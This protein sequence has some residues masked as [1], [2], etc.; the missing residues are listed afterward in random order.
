MTWPENSI[1]ESNAK[2]YTMKIK[3][4]ILGCICT[5]ISW[6]STAQYVDIS[7]GKM[8]Y[9]G[10][11]EQLKSHESP[12]W[13]NNAKLGIFIHWGL[14]SV[15]AYASTE[16]SVEELFAEMGK[17]NPDMAK[18]QA[19]ARKWFINNGYAEWYLN[20]LRIKGS[21][22][23]EYHKENYGLEY[24]YYK[25]SEDFSR[26]TLQWDSDAM[27]ELF[28]KAGARYVV[29]TTKHHD[30]YTLWPSRVQ[31]NN[32]PEDIQPVQRDIVGDLTQSVRKK[33][34]RMGLYYSGGLD[35][36]FNRTPIYDFSGLMA[37]VPNSYEYGG[38]AD[39]HLRE[40]IEK[41]QPAILWNDIT[42]PDQGNAKGII[43]DYY[44]LIPDGVI[45]NRWGTTL[46]LS[47]FDT[48]EYSKLDSIQQYK[49][50]TC[51]GLGHSFGY[52]KFEDDSHTLSSTDL[53]QLFV[54][55]VSKNGNLLLNVG[56]KADGTIPEIQRS[57]LEDLG[58]WMAINGKAIYDTEP[59]KRSEAK[60]ASGK[61]VRF[62]QK[63]KAL[64]V[65]FLGKPGKNESIQ[66]LTLAK[67]STIRLLEG[68]R[69]LKWKQKGTTLEIRFPQD[70][71]GKHA[72]A[73]EVS[74]LPK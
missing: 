41:Y 31:N 42:Y 21:P 53:V 57:R 47:D 73:L 74:P 70:F 50:E 22:T 63:D 11:L 1:Y 2:T 20:S 4:A 10:D 71:D 29:L 37:T 26:E 59:W 34:M 49:W 7:E 23:Y 12:E 68:G 15:P 51:R 62:T 61:E 55:I 46:G 72:V 39:A 67:G 36:T 48:P 54:D 45:N 6:G 13:F 38:I 65:I 64:Y 25:F 24:N 35:W 52:N 30:G 33:G 56:P 8:V 69:E 28:K 18:L 27:A 32:L 66:E 3:N 40:L 16:L 58:N 5:I 14:Y 43:A 17:E 60:T 44:N 9:S 19:A